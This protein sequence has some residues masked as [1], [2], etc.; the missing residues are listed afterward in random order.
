MARKV[1]VWVY[2]RTPELQLL[3]L[4]RSSLFGGEWHP[5]TGSAEPGERLLS[6]ACR[7]LFE[8]T[9]LRGRGPVRSL[10][11]RFVF[12]DGAR[13]VS[14]SAYWTEAERG[15][16]RL[17]REHVRYRWTPL[18]KARELLVWESQR[19]ALQQLLRRLFEPSQKAR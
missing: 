4:Q 9:G 1:Q 13:Q 3:L 11:Y 10:R 14:E 18:Q 7:E 12:H 6:A 19:E 2:R 17:S 8:E 5:I 16:I 15:R